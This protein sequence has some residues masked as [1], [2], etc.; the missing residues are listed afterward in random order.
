[1][2]KKEESNENR[3]KRLTA[4]SGEITTDNRKEKTKGKRQETRGSAEIQRMKEV[5]GR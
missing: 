2:R 4:S 1:V 5:H 3:R